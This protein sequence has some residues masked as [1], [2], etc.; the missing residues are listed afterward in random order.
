MAPNLWP[1][2]TTSVGLSGSTDHLLVHAPLPKTVEALPH[3]LSRKHREWG[4]NRRP[5][6]TVWWQNR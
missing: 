1:A 3:S 4:L 5:G 2:R 6:P